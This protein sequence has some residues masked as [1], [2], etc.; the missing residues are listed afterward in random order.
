MTRLSIDTFGG[1]A[2]VYD[3]RRLPV[4]RSQI[5]RNVHFDAG[6]VSSAFGFAALAGPTPVDGSLLTTGN[7]GRMF[8]T[9]SPAGSD[10]LFRFYGDANIRAVRNPTPA[11]Q[12]WRV[13][14]TEQNDGYLYNI[15][16]GDVTQRKRLGIL[17]PSSQPVVSITS[18]IAPLTILTLTLAA[19]IVIGATAHNLNTGDKVTIKMPAG[20][21]TTILDGLVFPIDRIDANS[22]KL[23]GSDGT[24]TGYSAYIAGHGGTA[25]RVVNA[26]EYE[27]RVYCYTYVNRFGEESPP[28]PVSEYIDAVSDQSTIAVRC[29]FVPETYYEPVQKIRVYRLASG[30]NGDA[31]VFTGEFLPDIAHRDGATDFYIFSDSVKGI[32]LGDA[33]QSKTWFPPIRYLKGLT[34]APNGYCVA[35][36]DNELHFSEP[37]QPQAW[38][39]E[40]VKALDV[41]ILG[42]EFYGSTMVIATAGAPHYA[43]GT[44]PSSVT[45]VGMPRDATCV[46]AL[47]LTS[48]G[49]SVIYPAYDG[50]VQ[51]TPMI[52]RNLTEKVFNQLQ[53]RALYPTIT[54][55]CFYDQTVYLGTTG[56]TYAISLDG[57]VRTLVLGS[58]SAAYAYPGT[59]RPIFAI[60]GSSTPQVL[61]NGAAMAGAWKSK[62]FEFPMPINFSCGRLMSDYTPTKDGVPTSPTG[63]VTLKL[64]PMDQIL[65]A[66]LGADESTN[67][68]DG[69]YTVVIDNTGAFRLPDM[70]ASRAWTVQLEFAGDAGRINGIVLARSMTELRES[71]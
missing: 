41:Q 16:S 21:G 14:Y 17:A 44:D 29:T 32:A 69:Y 6:D 38:P 68:A 55:A 22:F 67:A 36:K 45:V 42:I 24:V 48:A 65:G 15:P 9:V 60:A 8:H 20:S 62:C 64:F 37:F 71:L 5:A 11:D 47:G 61:G 50:L 63:K 3:S 52:V 13:Y 35:F 19:P 1:I 49:D 31:M 40:Y 43:I 2:P 51:V 46:N 28:S 30:F 23:R 34:V 56:D 12:F 10:Y 25:T 70:E 58:L 4:E 57:S 7:V 27:T 33:I 66:P 59:A 18:G 54:S 39:A 53:W 26:D